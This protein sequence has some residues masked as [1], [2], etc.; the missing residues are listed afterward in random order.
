MAAFKMSLIPTLFVVGGFLF[1]GGLC[2][3]ASA[4]QNGSGGG[5][6]DCS[7][8]GD[9]KGAG[10]EFTIKDPT[11]PCF[12]YERPAGVRYVL[13]RGCGGGSAGGAG[14]VA[15][16]GNGGNGSEV[17]EVLLGPFDDESGTAMTI[18]LGQGG[19]AKAPAG[20]P[21]TVTLTRPNGSVQRLALFQGAGAPAA[22]AAH[23][24]GAPRAS[25][26]SDAGQEGAAIR[27]CIDGNNNG[28]A[29]AGGAGGGA[30]MEPGGIGGS[31][32]KGHNKDG[33]RGGACAGGGGGVQGRPDH[34]AH[35]VYGIPS[36]AGGDG[37][38]G[39]L[40]L[41]PLRSDIAAT[42]KVLSDFIKGAVSE[43]APPEKTR[44]DQ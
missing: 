20:T 41:I 9:A 27:T 1:T 44:G 29:N 18:R 3:Q 36:G 37:G 13:A 32:A 22:G 14:S 25:D 34:A 42:Q 12:K 35:C 39:L 21:T 2:T 6:S 28:Y 30:G 10:I 8:T 16:G 26:T 33:A 24:E 38:P 17:R 40:T 23:V 43:G 5:V 4:Q 31:F 15:D 7:A 19:T 11:K